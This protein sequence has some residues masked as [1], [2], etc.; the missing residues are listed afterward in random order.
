MNDIALVLKA[1][2]FAAHKHRDQRR[3]DVKATPYI[4]HPL[5]VAQALCEEGGVD[6]PI[7]LAAALLHDTIED[8]E[9]TY[10]ELR[11]QFGSAHR[12]DS[13]PRSRTTSSSASR[14]ASACNF[15]KGRPRE[16]GGAASEDRR[17]ALQPARHPGQSAGE[18]VGEAEA[19]VLR[20][21]EGGGGPGAGR[22]SE[23]GGEV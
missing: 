21:G 22:E 20:L 12:Q 13:S 18:V 6:D 2:T 10:D 17:Q 5:A 15:R 1:A 9:T 11:G 14:R 19:R 16:C 23:V 8:T 4:N 3:K 7:I